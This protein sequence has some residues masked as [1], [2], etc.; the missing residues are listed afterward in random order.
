MNQELIVISDV[1]VAKVWDNIES[2]LPSNIRF[3]NPNRILGKI[4]NSIKKNQILI[5][6]GD[7]VD[8]F[9]ANYDNEDENYR[10]RIEIRKYLGVKRKD[11]ETRNDIA[12]QNEKLK[13][14]IELYKV[15][16]SV[17]Q[18]KD[19]LPQFAELLAYC[20]GTKTY[21][22]KERINPYKEMIEKIK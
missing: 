6:N 10:F 14:Q 8:S 2:A 18:S 13:Q 5:I 9:Y 3:I 22:Q 15:C 21:E 1:H 4:V 17:R 19:P 11:C 20:N 12:L 16:K 7:L